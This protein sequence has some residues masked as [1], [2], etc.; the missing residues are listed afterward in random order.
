[1]VQRF[2]HI[3][4]WL[5][6]ALA[7]GYLAGC[8]E[9][10]SDSTGVVASAL[11][12]SVDRSQAVDPAQPDKVELNSVEL[13]SVAAQ[14]LEAQPV[15]AQKVEAQKVEAQ[16]V[17]AQKVAAKPADVEQVEVHA[18]DVEPPVKV[19]RSTAEKPE[20]VDVEVSKKAE[21]DDSSLTQ[22]PLVKAEKKPL[23]P[24]P[25]RPIVLLSE[26][27]KKT[28][29]KLVGDTIDAVEVTDIQ[30]TRHKLRDLLSDELTVLIFWNEKSIPAMEQFRR[31]PVDILGTFASYRVKVIAAHV[32]GDVA[33]TRILTGDAADKIVS[34]VDADEKLFHEFAES[35]VPRTYVLD[36]EGRILW[37]DIEYSFSAV[38][39]LSNALTFFLANQ[40]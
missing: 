37:F 6:S 27:H 1:M 39:A 4:S 5:L 29:R 23:D 14:P 8:S 3:C 16:K 11:V 18:A 20:K 7:L 21:T 33:R 32:G 12:A 35:R 17:E 26:A 2:W 30:G 15:E 36:K 22:V 40:K 19:A 38:R 24:N 34:L 13:N 28:C 10:Q 31:I 9:L 25:T